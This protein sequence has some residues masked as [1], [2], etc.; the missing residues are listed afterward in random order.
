MNTGNILR[1][2]VLVIAGAALV[3]LFFQNFPTPFIHFADQANSFLSGRLDLTLM[4]GHDAVIK[5]GK[6]YWPQGPF[7]S[8]LLM[9]L[10][11]RIGPWSSQGAVQAILVVALAF[12]LFR[13][14]R[15]KGYVRE[16]ALYLAAAFLGGS[17][18]VGL[19]TD[20][21][22]WFFAQVVAV[23]VSVAV[24]YEWETSRRLWL[25][26]LGVGLVVA[27]RPLAAGF[28]LVFLVSLWRRRVS[29]TA[30]AKIILP[31]ICIG[32]ALLWFNAIRFGDPLDNG[33]QTNNLGP[34]SE[35]YRAMGIFSLKHLPSNAYWYF[36]AS[37]EP[38]TDLVRPA[39]LIPPYVSYNDWG[40]SILLISP[41]FLYALRTLRTGEWEERIAWV[42]IGG[43][44]AM[45]LLY[46]NTGWRSFGPRYTADFLPLLYMLL[47]SAFP[48]RRL[49]GW[50]KT[51]VVL[52]V[53]FNAYLLVM[54]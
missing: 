31:L 43:T 51:L 5:D 45:L 20:P 8:V 46:F 40:L 2:G 44:L 36:L 42:V 4:D 27:T 53:A 54:R 25:V 47:L 19:W 50:H 39:R 12:L 48:G 21:K 30:F 28:L 10:I 37:V 1:G 52:S 38:V 32:A 17:V 49:S 11:P 14:A 35:P 23:V 9:P 18:F 22:S 6:L 16:D 13:L 3:F 24:L 7:P 29:W 41:F 26:G 33:Y 15:L 34:D